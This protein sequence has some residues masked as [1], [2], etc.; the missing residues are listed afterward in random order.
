MAD[1]VTGPWDVDP[2]LTGA[3][4]AGATPFA[5]PK[6]F[7]NV[8]SKEVADKVKAHNFVNGFVSA[9]QVEGQTI[10]VNA[11]LRFA[12]A[13]DAAAA[14]NDMVEAARTM[15]V[16]TPPVEDATIPD[17]PETQATRYVVTERDTGRRWSNVHAFTAHGPY[18]LVQTAESTDG[19]DKAVE[20]AAKTVTAQ[21]P[22]ID[23]FQATDPAKL[24]DLP[25]D[26]SGLL[27]RTLPAQDN[28]AFGILTGT[29]G[30][31]GI[32]HFQGNPV[33]SATL[34]D[35]TGMDTAVIGLTTVYQARD[36]AGA[37]QIT[38]AF[39]Q[40]T[41]AG[42]QPADP[43]QGLDSSKCVKLASSGF[44]CTA[45]ADRYALE[46]NATQLPAAHQQLAA[47]S[48]MVQAK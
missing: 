17:H 42:G 46:A 8:V 26:P 9:R 15:K 21:A 39:A 19:F 40:E 43:V 10:L 12:T 11:V 47:Q 33:S 14:A 23:Q 13:E 18:V 24:A 34:F 38:Q 20:L 41:G 5:N 7:A 36:A 48:E 37:A 27:A 22:L 4:G 1:Y 32:L 25:R 6:G 28:I 35:Q 29:Y 45:E 2:T 31:H 16:L 3:Y 44:Y 30:R